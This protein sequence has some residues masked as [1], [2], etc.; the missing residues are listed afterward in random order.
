M[1]L[2]LRCNISNTS[3]LKLTVIKLHTSLSF[4]PSD[5][6]SKEASSIQ[7]P[8]GMFKRDSVKMLTMYPQEAEAGESKVQGQLELHSKTLSQKKR[9]EKAPSPALVA[10]A[11]NPSYLERRKWGGG[12]GGGRKQ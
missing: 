11:C 9:K 12:L 10:H 8:S 1:I 7:N 6:P 5:F 2:S 3:Y 4:R